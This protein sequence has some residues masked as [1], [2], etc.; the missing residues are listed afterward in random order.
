MP[1]SSKLPVVVTISVPYGMKAE[2]MK[3]II[4]NALKAN[5]GDC[6]EDTPGVVATLKPSADLYYAWIE[7]NASNSNI[8]VT[9]A[10]ST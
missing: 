5:Y 4:I 8:S 1:V 3:E 10:L 2:G 9:T 6:I 7:V